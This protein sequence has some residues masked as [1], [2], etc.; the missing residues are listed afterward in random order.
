MDIGLPEIF[1]IFVI[2]LLVLGPER[3]PSAAKKIAAVVIRVQR[4]YS[5]I[6]RDIEREINADEIRQRIHNEEVLKNLGESTEKLNEFE[7]TMAKTLNKDISE[8]DKPP[9]ESS[10]GAYSNDTDNM[11]SKKPESVEDLDWYRAKEEKLKNENKIDSRSN[12]L[13]KDNEQTSS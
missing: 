10:I 4:S 7:K 1:I 2:A 6:T 3:L 5:K 13:N 9:T 8:G 12:G 11:E